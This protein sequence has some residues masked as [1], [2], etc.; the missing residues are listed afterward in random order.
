MMPPQKVRSRKRKSDS[1]FSKP[2]ASA[3]LTRQSN[4]KDARSFSA[5]VVTG[6]SSRKPDRVASSTEQTASFEHPRGTDKQST[7]RDPSARHDLQEASSQTSD[8]QMRLKKQAGSFLSGKE[9][10]HDPKIA[11]TTTTQS[12]YIP[13]AQVLPEYVRFPDVLLSLH[14]TEFSEP[15]ANLHEAHRAGNPHDEDLSTQTPVVAA[16]APP[17]QI[18][19]EIRPFHSFSSPTPNRTI[20]KEVRAAVNGTKSGDLSTSKKVQ[21]GTEAEAGE[22]PDKAKV[23]AAS[24]SKDDL[25]LETN[26]LPRHDLPSPVLPREN[27][28]VYSSGT[29]LP[30]TLTASSNGTK[31]HDGQGVAPDLDEFDL[32]QAI[33]DAGSFLQSWDV[34]RDLSFQARTDAAMASGRAL[35]QQPVGVSEGKIGS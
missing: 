2:I 14:S 20:P 10:A 4:R 22:R 12:D 9:S 24:R 13:S 34:E 18:S 23:D 1:S 35:L 30:F 7:T 16:Q 11:T 17:D 3:S 5:S 28:S 21:F 31:P 32:S 29:L 26:G 33:A 6:T 15:A 25:V 19:G 27:S 8:V